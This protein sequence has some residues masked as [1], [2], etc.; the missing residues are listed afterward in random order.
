MIELVRIMYLDAL[1]RLLVLSFL[2]EHRPMQR[3]ECGATV[4][5]DAFTMTM[6]HR[7][8]TLSIQCHIKISG[9]GDGLQTYVLEFVLSA[10]VICCSSPKTANVS[11]RSARSG[12]FAPFE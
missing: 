9:F 1:E 2:Q 3:N 8:E 12:C 5:E 10:Q 11:F 6:W 4:N 7:T